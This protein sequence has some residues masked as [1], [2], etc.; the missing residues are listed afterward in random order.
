MLTQLY[1]IETMLK[2]YPGHPVFKS[3][4]TD[5]FDKAL[6]TDKV[7]KDFL[8]GKSAAEIYQSFAVE[9]EKFEL[10]RQ[11]YFIYLEK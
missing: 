10:I 8:K 11:K 5:M 4:H 1:C 9:V 6:G 2:L 3:S 7:R